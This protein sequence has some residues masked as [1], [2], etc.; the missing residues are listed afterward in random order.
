M[1]RLTTPKILQTFPNK[2]VKAIGIDFRRLEAQIIGAYYAEDGQEGEGF[3]ITKAGDNFL[4]FYDQ[5]NTHAYLYEAIRTEDDAGEVD[6]DGE[7]NGALTVEDGKEVITLS[8]ARHPVEE[9]P[10]SK[11]SPVEEPVTP[12]EAPVPVA[13]VPVEEPPTI[14]TEDPSIIIAEEGGN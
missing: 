3:T 1:I 11:E 8:T 14:I 13:G 5:W 7:L 6:V 10:I 12:V 9:T 2:I 4:A